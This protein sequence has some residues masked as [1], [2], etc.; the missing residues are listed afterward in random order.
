MKLTIESTDKFALVD[1]GRVRIWEGRTESVIECLVFVAL[2][3]VE[4][5]KDAQFER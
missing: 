2:V 4:E 5:G 3:G 1:G